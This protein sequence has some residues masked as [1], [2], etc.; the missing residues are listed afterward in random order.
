MSSP[1]VSSAAP[2]PSAGPHSSCSGGGGSRAARSEVRERR[3]VPMNCRRA[4]TI[5]AALLLAVPMACGSSTR[6][7]GAPPARDSAVIVGSFDFAESRLLAEIYSQAL[8]RGGIP[9]RRAF[10]MGPRELVY[11]SLPQGLV[12]VVPEYAG[13][14]LRFL[15]LNGDGF[16]GSSDATHK[17]LVERLTGTQATALAPSPAQNTNAFVVLRT[18]A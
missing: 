1:A 16:T 8:E 6:G 13:T 9:V 10:G 15:D 11:P 7:G 3:R 12:D 2:S 18:R 5:A 4:L 14:L 17:R